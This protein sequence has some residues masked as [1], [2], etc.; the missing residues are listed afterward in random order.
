MEFLKEFRSIA[1]DFCKHVEFLTRYA[2]IPYYVVDKFVVRAQT[3]KILKSIPRMENAFADL[4]KKQLKLAKINF[5]IENVPNYGTRKCDNLPDRI[6]A[7]S[8][9][10]TMWQFG[11]VRDAVVFKN[12]AY[13]WF[14]DMDD[15]FRTHSLI[16][17]MQMGDNIIET[18]VIR[19]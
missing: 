13:I 10:D 5:V 3:A 9:H 12:H 11:S 16:N 2:P 17:K 18:A 1:P 6:T 4:I 19:V 7:K 15:A 14:D 8:I